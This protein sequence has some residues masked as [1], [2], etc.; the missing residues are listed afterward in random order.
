[1]AS[2][3]EQPVRR[4]RHGVRDGLTVMAVSAAFSVGLALVLALAA[5][6]IVAAGN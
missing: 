6:L 1:M 5:R 4:V 3:S 2:V